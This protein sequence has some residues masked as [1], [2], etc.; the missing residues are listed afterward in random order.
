M[1][2]IINQTTHDNDIVVWL[3]IRN[4]TVRTNAR[5]FQSFDDPRRVNVSVA[6]FDDTL[7][8][9]K[10][11]ASATFVVDNELVRCG[12]IETFIERTTLTKR[13]TKE[14]E[15]A[16]LL[17]LDVIEQREQIDYYEIKRATSRVVQFIKRNA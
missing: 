2:T 7:R 16:L 5:W 6:T 11:T 3:A 4:G 10:R 9:F 8:T 17:A 1:I 13:D 12:T 14:L 15:R